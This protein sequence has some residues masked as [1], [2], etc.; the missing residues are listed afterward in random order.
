MGS[1]Y[2]GT[3]R[4]WDLYL[5]LDNDGRYERTVRMEPDYERRDSGHWNYT[6]QALQGTPA[7]QLIGEP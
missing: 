4:R 7:L 5:F 6:E 3:G 2:T 1:L